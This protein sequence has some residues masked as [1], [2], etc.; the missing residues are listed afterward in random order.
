MQA[1][2]CSNGHPNRVAQFFAHIVKESFHSRTAQ[3]SL[4]WPGATSHQR[5]TTKSL[6][7]NNLSL[8]ALRSTFSSWSRT[9]RN[10]QRPAAGA[11]LNSRMANR[12]RRPCTKPAFLATS[13]AKRGILCSPITRRRPDG[14]ADPGRKHALLTRVTRYLMCLELCP[15]PFEIH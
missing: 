5:K 9:Q 8:P 2:P 10:T 11:S 6:G 1:A 7:V 15:L 13:P 14:L 3:L 12:P 4:D